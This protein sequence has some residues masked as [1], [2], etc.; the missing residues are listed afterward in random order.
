MATYHDI[1]VPDDAYSPKTK[2]A[3]HV[4]L[5][6]ILDSHLLDATICNDYHHVLMLQMRGMKKEYKSNVMHVSGEPDDWPDALAL[7]CKHMRMGGTGPKAFAAHGL[8]PDHIPEPEPETVPN[9]PQSVDDRI[10]SMMDDQ[11]YWDNL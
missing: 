6:R 2:S 9:Q 7:A 11:S 1:I 4:N 5:V 3:L 10:E 8:D